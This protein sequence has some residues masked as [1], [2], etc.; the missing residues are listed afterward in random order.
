M[1]PSSIL[2]AFITLP[3]FFNFILKRFFFHR[4]F[5][6]FVVYF[7]LFDR[8]SMRCDALGRNYRRVCRWGSWCTVHFLL[9]LRLPVMRFIEP[10]ATDRAQRVWNKKSE[11]AV[12]PVDQQKCR[13]LECRTLSNDLYRNFV[14]IVESFV[15][16]WRQVK[17]MNLWIRGNSVKCRFVELTFGNFWIAD[18]NCAP[19]AIDSVGSSVARNP[20]FGSL[21]RFHDDCIVVR[22]LAITTA[23]RLNLELNVLICINVKSS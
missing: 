22:W 14:K 21:S 3:F 17:A 12:S 19:V 11:P 8:S 18:F 10:L 5:P 9:Q 2:C 7:S 1:S 15:W 4:L 23:R 6:F 16:R 20:L 13:W